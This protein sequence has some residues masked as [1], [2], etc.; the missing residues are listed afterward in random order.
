MAPQERERKVLAICVALAAGKSDSAGSLLSDLM[1]Y[2]RHDY[3]Y[4]D[5]GSPRGQGYEAFEKA[6]RAIRV[7]RF[8]QASKHFE[9]GA[10]LY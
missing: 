5:K 2:L 6:A 9:V 1:T 7:G 3:A 4:T 8:P 10:A